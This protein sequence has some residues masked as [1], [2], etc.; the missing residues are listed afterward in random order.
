MELF[1]QDLFSVYPITDI[2]WNVYAQ[3]SFKIAIK[4]TNTTGTVR[5]MR[6]IRSGRDGSVE[7]KNGIPHL[8]EPNETRWIAIEPSDK[9]FKYDNSGY[10]GAAAYPK[11]TADISTQWKPL[12]SINMLTIYES[13]KKARMTIPFYQ[14][15]ATFISLYPNAKY[16]VNTLAK[17]MKK[18]LLLGHMDLGMRGK[19]KV[20][21]STA[22]V[23]GLLV[24]D[25]KFSSLQPTF[26]MGYRTVPIDKGSMLIIDLE[27]ES[28]QKLKYGTVKYNIN[29]NEVTAPIIARI[30][31]APAV[32]GAQWKPL[33]VNRIKI[34]IIKTLETAK[35]ILCN[36]SNFT[37][38]TLS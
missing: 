2:R 33:D 20:Y 9:S 15:A 26:P 31:D 32:K 27:S 11:K 34:P 35:D 3:Q 1:F 6:E 19:I 14:I 24:K 22:C 12:N 37:P 16:D 4:Y 18:Q 8:L 29:G 36:S 28:S 7:L 5:E 21:Q 30:I 38:L 10:Y 25:K 23:L 13:L 17:M